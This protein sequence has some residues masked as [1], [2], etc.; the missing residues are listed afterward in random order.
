MAMT[1]AAMR[2]APAASA[3]MQNQIF[4]RQ[5]VNR[6]KAYSEQILIDMSRGHLVRANARQIVLDAL[7]LCEALAAMAVYEES[8]VRNRP[9]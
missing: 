8:A 6:I 1:K 2:A 3:H 4:A 7:A 9:S 5:S